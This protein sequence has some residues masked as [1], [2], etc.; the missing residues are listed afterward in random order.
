MSKTMLLGDTHG[1]TAFAQR[2]V[3][4]A[5]A[6]NCTRI[7]Q[8]GD[9]G[10]W[11]HLGPNGVSFLRK[12]NKTCEQQ[13]VDFFW[14]DGNHENHPLLWER[15]KPEN[16][17]EG[18]T[19]WPIRSRIFYIPRGTYW[20]WEGTT[21]LGMG[22]AVSIDRE[23]RTPGESW[24]PEE[25]ITQDDLDKIKDIKGVDILVT[26]DAPFNPLPPHFAYKMDPESDR[27][28]QIMR[29][30]L[31]HVK[32]EINFHG[33]YHHFHDTDHLREDGYTRVIGLDCDGTRR[34]YAILYTPYEG[35]KDIV[36][37]WQGETL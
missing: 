6:L 7:L 32:P 24:W 28:R 11:E 10:Y 12:L 18:K 17:V 25:Q 27:H 15:Y 35:R 29:K 23:Y 37:P 3:E 22:G 16:E 31:N 34:S 8:L 5:R 36:F 9:F 2:A 4:I 14:I 19:F 13:E 30:V 33:H 21:F 26:H 20:E 1:N